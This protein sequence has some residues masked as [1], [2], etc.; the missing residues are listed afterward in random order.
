MGIPI[1]EIKVK[2]WEALVKEL[3]HSGATKF[4]LLYE[5]GEGYYTK[6]R[7]ELFKDTSIEEIV[8]EIKDK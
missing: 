2:G 1:P 6:E 3:G 4:I 7:K 5:S 8:K